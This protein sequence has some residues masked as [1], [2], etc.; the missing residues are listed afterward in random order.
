VLKFGPG[1]FDEGGVGGG[2]EKDDERDSRNCEKALANEK[3]SGANLRRRDSYWLEPFL[4]NFLAQRD[5][6]RHLKEG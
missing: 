5:R 2:D 6:P 3:R 4:G 1:G